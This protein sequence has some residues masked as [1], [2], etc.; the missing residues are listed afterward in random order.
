MS[1]EK[2]LGRS[3][4]SHSIHIAVGRD[5]Q[6][7]KIAQK[8]DLKLERDFLNLERKF[9]SHAKWNQR[10]ANKNL[11]QP[12]TNSAQ[13]KPPLTFEQFMQREKIKNDIISNAKKVANQHI[14]RH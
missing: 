14:R 8:H 9:A 3:V 7:L 11:R 5:Y 4:R 6:R 13:E 2:Y 1:S 12:A 10:A